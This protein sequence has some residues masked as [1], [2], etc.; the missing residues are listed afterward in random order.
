MTDL[1]MSQLTAAE[2]NGNLHLVPLLQEAN[3]VFHLRVEVADIGVQTETDF[4]DFHDV[5]IF[6]GFLFPF[7]LFE[8]ILAVI[9]DPADRRRGRRS[10]FHQVEIFFVG[11]PLGVPGRH[12]PQLFAAVPDDADLAVTNLL[13]NLHLL[14]CYG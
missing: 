4:L 9:H 13:V 14:T 8:P 11:K 5:L 12:N 10:D 3:G 2:P 6:P 7:G 1:R